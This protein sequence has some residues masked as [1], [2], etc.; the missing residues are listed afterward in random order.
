MYGLPTLTPTYLQVQEEAAKANKGGAVDHS[1]QAG[2]SDEKAAGS[3]NAGAD[4]GGLN[5]GVEERV[6]KQAEV[7]DGVENH[8]EVCGCMHITF[9]C[10]YLCQC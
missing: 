7:I 8:A 4:G 2:A 5:L 9:S 10:A 1:K 3:A 6:G